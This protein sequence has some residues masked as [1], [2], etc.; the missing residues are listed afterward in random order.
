MCFQ[1]EAIVFLHGFLGT[2]EDWIPIMEAISAT[3]RCISFDL[4]GHGKSQPTENNLEKILTR[5][6]N[7][8]EQFMKEIVKVISSITPGKVVLVGYSMGARMALYT[9][10]RHSEK[11]S[12]WR[13]EI[14]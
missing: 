13:Y 11:V 5:K 3:R 6:S 9:A 8:F 7:S 1:K 14:F 12:L 4:P 2:S 10:L